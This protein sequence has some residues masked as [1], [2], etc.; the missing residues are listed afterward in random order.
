M[1]NQV[2]LCFKPLAQ[3]SWENIF[4]QIEQSILPGGA[5]CENR[6]YASKVAENIA[7]LAGVLHVIEGYEGVEI[8]DETLKSATVIVLWYAQE[9]VRL[10]SPPSPSDVI[11]AHAS[12]LDEWLIRFVQSTGQLQISKTDLLQLGPNRL[13]RRDVLDIAIKRLVHTCRVSCWVSPF[14]PDGRPSR[15]GTLTI[16]LVDA[17]YGCLARGIQPHGF[18]PLKHRH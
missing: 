14:S 5:F 18:V 15:K 9:F 12:L 7:R 17:Y 4:N 6:D 11:D 8:S 13:R 2:E 3:A 1:S 16:H 10:F